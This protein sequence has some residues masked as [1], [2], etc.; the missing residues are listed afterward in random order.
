MV[1]SAFSISIR[2]EFSYQSIDLE[3]I[4]YC[5]ETFFPQKVKK[6]CLNSITEENRVNCSLW[7]E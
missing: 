7:N 5:F 4:T 1:Q 3:E 6:R 2:K